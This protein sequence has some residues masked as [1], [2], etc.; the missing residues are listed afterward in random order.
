M[1]GIVDYNAGNI[2]SV[3][4]A[5]KSLNIDCILSKN[6]ANLANCQKII[7]PG[8]GDAFFAMQQLKETG[9]N[10]FLKE[11][12][13]QNKPV[14]GICLGSQ[15]IFDWSEEG[16]VNCLGLVEGKIRHFY[17]INP[18]LKEKETKVP[19]IGFNNLVLQNG[20]CPI[21]KGLPDNP[22]FYFVHSYVICPD[23]PQV[24]KAYADYGIKVPA[25]IQ[26][27][28]LFACQFHPEKSGPV[29]LKILRNFCEL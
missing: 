29:G 27:G 28:N 18:E 16:D 23:N 7:F 3:E 21:L 1:I 26:K 25:V 19:Q 22:D 13:K 6:P 17:S 9:F 5:L 2:T 14:L 11:W 20:E 4:R 15:I 8:V 24:V 12:V 10:L